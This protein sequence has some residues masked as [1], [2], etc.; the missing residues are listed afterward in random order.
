MA[1][2]A[3]NQL[4][5]R[6]QGLI[7]QA[8]ANTGIEIVSVELRGAGKA[9]LLRVY[10]DKPGGV[11]HADCELVSERVSSLLDQQDVMPEESYTLEVSSLGPD[12]KLQSPR[13]FERVL[14][15]KVAVTLRSPADGRARV[16][17]KVVAVQDDRLAL[18]VKPGEM[19]EIALAEVGRAKLK[20]EP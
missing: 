14:G 5:Q 17:G 20:F 8:A 4:V 2:P 10:I 11:T 12:R 9:R 13:D 19:L 1:A 15:H 3:N 7:T 6:I 18:E 16:E